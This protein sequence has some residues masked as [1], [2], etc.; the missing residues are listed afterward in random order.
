MASN[1]F[2]CLGFRIFRYTSGEEG[3]VLRPEVVGDIDDVDEISDLAHD[4]LGSFHEDL[5]DPVH[6]GLDQ[7]L[8]HHQIHQV[9]RKSPEEIT[10]RDV[11]YSLSPRFQFPLLPWLLCVREFPPSL[12]G[13]LVLTAYSL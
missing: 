2:R 4:A 1:S 8:I 3:A 12:H 10:L 9:V 11:P 5:Q 7:F 13:M 6:D